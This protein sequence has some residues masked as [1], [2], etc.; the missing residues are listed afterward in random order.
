MISPDGTKLV[1]DLWR[2]VE[3][4]P[5]LPSGIGGIYVV[6]RASKAT[7]RVTTEE[8]H[9]LHPSWLADGTLVFQA[10]PVDA[11]LLRALADDAGIRYSVYHANADGSD[12]R[13]LVENAERPS[14]SG[15]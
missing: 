5:E 3:Q 9:A 10:T 7:T 2:P 4:H 6:D 12:A 11:R 13:V 15:P 14:A 8:L 1:F